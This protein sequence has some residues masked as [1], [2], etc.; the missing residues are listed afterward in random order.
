ME[1]Y[2]FINKNFIIFV[3]QLRKKMKII[4]LGDIH[5]R[6][7]W[8]KIVEIEGIENVMYVFIGDYFDSFHITPEKQF[9]NFNKILN[10]KRQYPYNVILLIG[11]HDFH[12]FDFCNKQ[13][14]GFNRGFQYMFANAL[15]DALKENI[16][17][18]VYIH[19]NLLFSH[20]GVTNTW[21]DYTDIDKGNLENSINEYLNYRP[22]IF[23]FIPGS[24][25]DN[26]GD[27]ITQSPIWVRPLSL[28]EDGLE[29]YIHIVGHTAQPNGIRKIKNVYLIDCVYK[30]YLSIENSI[31]TI[32]KIEEI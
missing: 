26:E 19:E 24:R 10:F 20:A 6:N 1:K 14:T 2:F 32:K 12:Y 22:R 27:D 21:C 31:I 3:Y 25:N 11:N 17:Q 8:E 28:L 7:I 13:Y 30:E 15:H 29:E 5:G 16:I 23:N 4:A 18:A 9:E